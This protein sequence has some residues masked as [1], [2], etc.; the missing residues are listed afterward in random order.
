MGSSGGLQPQQLSGRMSRYVIR[1]KVRDT[2]GNPVEGAALDLSGELVFTNSSGEF[3]LRVGRPRRLILTVLPA[4]FLLP[5]QWEV[6][7]A[8][9]EIDPAPESQATGADIILR[10]PAPEHR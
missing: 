10:R 9:A 7:S 8:P 5:G 1:G 3:F 2:E 6:V 4:E